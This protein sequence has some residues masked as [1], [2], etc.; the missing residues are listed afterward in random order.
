MTELPPSPRRRRGA[1]G[2]ALLA[3]V[4]APVAIAVLVGLAAPWLPPRP[5]WWAQL[6]A[7]GLPYA[8]WA[9]A[10][11]G[12][13]WLLGRR[14]RAV[15]FHAVLLLV[16]GV[17]AGGLGRLA[18]AGAAGPDD[19]VLTTFN[20]PQSGPSREALADSVV[21]F[22]QDAAPD[23]LL[24]QDARVAMRARGPAVEGVQVEAVRTRLP[25]QL[26]MPARLA[27]HPGW[28]NNATDVAFFVRDGAGVEVL[29]QEVL[30]IGV[31]R[32]PDVSLA[33]RSHLR[34]GGREFVVYNVHLRSFGSPKPWEDDAVS[35]LR[36]STWAPYLRQ[37]RGVYA[38]RGDEADQIADAIA[39]ETLPVV[40]AGDFN[41][42]ADNWSYHRLRTAGG[43]SRTD[44]TQAAGGRAWGRT[45]HAERPFVRID[46]VLADP[47][48]EVTGVTT[49]PVRF[50]DHRP[51]RVGLRWRDA[52]AEAETE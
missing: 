45:Y 10:A 17:R 35:L 22:V 21:A 48:L 3:L 9:L 6:V 30:I 50:S 8:S 18:E 16:V 2:R 13:A 14:W 12:V 31:E 26:E 46:F 51:V 25:Y 41:S 34:W 52:E 24:M 15:A 42:T 43:V 39:E 36:P 44:A 47:A 20:I 49:S 38:Q 29:E 27:N 5:Y 11:F 33:L 7:I 19:L 32:D 37:Y 4:E 1:A 28:Q 23:V 40:V